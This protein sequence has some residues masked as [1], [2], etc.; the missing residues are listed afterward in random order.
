[1][2]RAGQGRARSSTA[3]SGYGRRGSIA[4]LISE[5]VPLE[6]ERGPAGLRHCVGEA[7][8]HIELCRM[9]PALAI[10][11]EGVEGCCC[12]PCGNR[13]GADTGRPKKF[14]HVVLR[15]RHP[16]V[17][18]ATES[19]GRLEDR[20]RRGNRRLGA[21]QRIRQGIGIGFGGED[22]DDRGGVDVLSGMRLFRVDVKT[23]TSSRA[24]DKSQGFDESHR[25]R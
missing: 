12:L 11:G 25:W 20:D 22:G 7:I 15:L 16:G 6:Q 10:A 2:L 3:A 14:E 9:A 24:G 5:V 19:Q 1:M 18:L 23:T 8:P 4:E 21:V 13:D 17:P